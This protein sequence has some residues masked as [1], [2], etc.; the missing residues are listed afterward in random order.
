MQR[1]SA[2]CASR[3]SPKSL[4]CTGQIFIGMFF[5][6]TGN[7]ENEDYLKVKGEPPKQ[8]HSNVVRLYHAYPD[9]IT[10]GTIKYY[11]YYIPSVGT[12]FPEI[13]DSGGKLGIGASWNVGY[14]ACV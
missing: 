1:A 12:P 14:H 9:K 4:P 8:K 7:N 5:D 2:V 3:P 10:K 6:G 11:A 13:G